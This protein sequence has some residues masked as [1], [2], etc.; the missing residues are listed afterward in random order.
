MDEV[1][2]PNVNCFGQSTHRKKRSTLED[3]LP[4]SG[5]I[6]LPLEGKGDHVVVDEVTC[7]PAPLRGASIDY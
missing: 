1:I 4:L 6:V 2:P 5:A 3:N 7:G